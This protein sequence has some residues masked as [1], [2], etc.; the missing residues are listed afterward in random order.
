M[1]HIEPVQAVVAIILTGLLAWAAASDI[2]DRKI[3]NRVVLAVGLLF[4][5]WS[6]AAG[7]AGLSSAVLAGL[8]AFAV[9]FG[10]YLGGIVGAGDSKLFAAVALFAGVPLLP[11][12]ALATAMTGGVMGVASFAS[13]PRR[14]MAMVALRGK[15]DFGRGIPYGVAISVGGALTI[16]LK[17]SGFDPARLWSAAGF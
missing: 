9:G 1:R 15:G 2:R 11:F 17:V 13:R 3:P 16:W 14:A 6:V 4:V 8:I 5:A 7:G 10:L 12:F